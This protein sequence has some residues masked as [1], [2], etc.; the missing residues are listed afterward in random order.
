MVDKLSKY[1]KY[2]LI[3]L[4]ALNVIFVIIAIAGGEA[5]VGTFMVYA[6]CMIELTLDAILFAFIFGIVVKPESLKSIGMILAIVAV[7]ALISWLMSSATLSP[8]Y[9]ESMGVSK[10]TERFVDF[11]MIFT[12]IVMGGTIASVLYSAVS[13]LIN[14]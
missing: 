4:M 9:L 1:C 5:N 8:E 11:A 12:Y 6:Y 10:G 13:K 14:K 3:G 7:L 2:L